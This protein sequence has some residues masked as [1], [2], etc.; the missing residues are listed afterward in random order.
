MLN[1]LKVI[2]SLNLLFNFFFVL[3]IHLKTICNNKSLV[4]FKK[5]K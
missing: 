4:L 1:Y 2:F 3:I 5:L